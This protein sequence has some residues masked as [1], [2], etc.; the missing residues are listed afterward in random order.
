MENKIINSL[1]ED[2]CNDFGIL[3][4]KESTLFEHFCNYCMFTLNSPDAYGTDHLL[5]KEVHTGDGGDFGIDGL[6]IL[7]NDIIVTNVEQFEDVVGNRRFSVK[8]VFVQAKTSSYFDSGDM[9]KTGHGIK[10]FFS[11]QI[12]GANEQILKYKRL[13]E[14]IFKQSAQM[15]NQPDCLIYYVTTGKWI[16]D[17]NLINI[18]EECIEI[19]SNLNIFSEVHFLPIDANRLIAIYKE[20]KNA[21]TREILIPKTI[22]FPPDIKGI[23]KAF[24]GLVPAKEYLKLITDQDGI[25]LQG[26]F[27]DNVRSYLGEN[28]VNGEIIETLRNPNKYI[29]FPILNNGI[30][31]VAKSL[32]QSGDKYTLMDFQIVNGCQTSNVI[33]NC[34][35]EIHDDMVVPVK[36]IHTEEPELIN[37]VIRST[38]RQTQVLDE[39]FE[40][41]KVFHKSLQDYYNTFKNESD[42]LYY[43]RRTH[44]YDFDETS[45]KKANV[46][47]LPCQLLCILSMFYAE[48]HSVHRYY[49]ELLRSNKHRIFLTDHRLIAYYT[50]A[51]TLHRVEDAFRKHEIDWKWRQYKYHLVYMIQLFIRR[52]MKMSK[53]PALNSRDIE[54]LCNNILSAVNDQ[55]QLGAMLRLFVPILE[56]GKTNI[57]NINRGNSWPRIKEFTSFI[58]ESVNTMDLEFELMK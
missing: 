18:K 13:I 11:K 7:V 44:E 32:N 47:S 34:R 14:A 10:D 17:V 36:I 46:I 38:N 24:I 16:E 54:K 50:S 28:S 41:L 2:F 21:I 37:D 33:Y 22:S 57:P 55:K 9:L 15:R 51:W 53:L 31:I 49:G 56:N 4:K 27:Y 29:Q 6:M 20:I 26:L 5:F 23:E 1:L 45:I 43:E 52:L 3:E 8:F 35:E 12:S 48:P 40:S 39:A 42:H 25:L 58:T 30:T 19:L